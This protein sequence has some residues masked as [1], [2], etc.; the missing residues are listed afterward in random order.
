LNIPDHNS[1]IL[2]TIF[3]VKN[4]KI[5]CRGSGS[6]IRDLF[7][8]RSGMENFGSGIGN[9]DPGSA[10]LIMDKKIFEGYFLR[11]FNFFSG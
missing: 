2:E 10:T 7:D 3:W 5:L 1:E 8:P 6:G 9:K 11:L 4:T